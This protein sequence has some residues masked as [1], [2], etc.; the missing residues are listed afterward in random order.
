M[1]FFVLHAR[2][3]CVLI[4]LCLYDLLF[5]FIFS[6]SFWHQVCYDIDLRIAF[7][8]SSSSQLTLG[9]EALCLFLDLWHI[10]EFGSKSSPRISSFVVDVIS[11]LHI[12]RSSLT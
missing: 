4:A 12:I 6:L 11:S 3:D 9:G 7:S 2:S 10:F 5:Y 1:Q 8:G